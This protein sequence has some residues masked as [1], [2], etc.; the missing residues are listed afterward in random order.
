M[1][2]I[3]FV[4]IL[5][6]CVL[7]CVKKSDQVFLERELKEYSKNHVQ[8][9]IFTDSDIAVVDDLGQIFHD[10]TDFH[11]AV[12]FRNNKQ[13]PLNSGFIAVRG[14]REGLTR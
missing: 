9:Y 8:H 12:T 4:K 5:V 11:L 13:Q 7:Y 3:F 2:F 14:T 1:P 6:I 10:Y